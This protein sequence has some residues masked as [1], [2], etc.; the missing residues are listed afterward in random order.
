MVDRYVGR[1]AK[2]SG[3]L[4]VLRELGVWGNRPATRKARASNARL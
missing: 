1:V 2:R 3:L 4:R